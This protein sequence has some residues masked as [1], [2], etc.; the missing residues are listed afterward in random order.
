ME[1]AEREILQQFDIPD[2]YGE[3]TQQ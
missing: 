2:P 3:I 1:Q